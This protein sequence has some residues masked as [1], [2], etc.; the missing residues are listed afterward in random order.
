M[1][2]RV[3]RGVGAGLLLGGV[4]LH[5][6][7][8]AAG[9]IGHVVVGTDGG[10]LCGCGARSCLETWLAAPRLEA[11]LADAAQD[12]APA[13]ARDNIL[14]EAG[15]RLGILLAPIVGA[16]N[17]SEVVLSGPKRLLAG[18][19][20]EATRET[21][22][23]HTMERFHGGLALGLSTLGDDIVLRG[24]AVMVISSRLGVS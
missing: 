4:L 9:E 7:R 21:L 18:S 2:V 14:R 22:R 11:K 13:T 5:G 6:S 15:T 8:F 10:E 12:A 20:V 17:L 1:L 24:A 3:G 19:L 16:L 23:S